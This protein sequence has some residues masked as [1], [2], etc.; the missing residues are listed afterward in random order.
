MTRRRCLYEDGI[1]PRPAVG[2]T[3]ALQGD[4][5]CTVRSGLDWTSRG[6]ESYCEILLAM[7][8][9]GFQLLRQQRPRRQLHSDDGDNRPR[10]QKPVQKRRF[11]NSFFRNRRMS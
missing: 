2:R 3:A 5:W 6:C 10:R 4:W 11:L 1:P 7:S 8:S 9:T